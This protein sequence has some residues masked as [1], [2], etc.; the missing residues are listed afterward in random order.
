[1]PSDQVT[2]CPHCQAVFRVAPE[3]LA[4]AQGWLRCGQCQGVFDSTGL[5]VPWA[6]EPEVLTERMDLKAFLKEEDRGASPASA[7]VAEV[8]DE[9]LSFEQALATFPGRPPE[10]P[11]SDAVSVMNPSTLSE[12]PSPPVASHGGR[13]Q[14]RMWGLGL[15]LL[16]LFQLVW[17]SRSTWLQMPWITET[18]QAGCARGGCRLPA[19]RGP[20][21]L[22]IDSSHFVR[23]DKGYRLEW[24]LR[25]VS[26]WPLHMPA[27]EL[28]LR[29]EAGSVLVRRVLTPSEM[30]APP[31]LEPG[32]GWEGVLLL[33]V[34]DAPDLPVSGYHLLAF[35]P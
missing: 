18:A 15:V 27:M 33:Q 9:L 11:A 3:S 8:S 34:A 23:V 10:M 4:Q 25:S 2:R 30:A 5:T 29:D 26:A 35:Y 24:S 7:P 16:A 13:R 20:D 6:S 28:T 31:R 21:L 32:Q 19:W 1:M 22:K 17:A 14:V 12:A